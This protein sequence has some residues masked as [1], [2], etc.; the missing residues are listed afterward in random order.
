MT[1]MPPPK[2]STEGPR[3]RHVH[4]EM[5]QLV[6]ALQTNGPQAPDHLADLVGA[7]YWEPHRF[8]RALAFAVS[9]GLALD[10]GA[11]VRVRFL[12]NASRAAGSAAG[13]GAV[14]LVPETSIVRRGALTGVFVAQ[15]GKARLR[16]IR[17]GRSAGDR[18]EVLAGLLA[19][20]EVVLDP[21]G[22]TDGRAVEVSR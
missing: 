18:V 7:E 1:P 8:E 4:Y 12:G 3:D 15:E 14:L 21:S 20:D 16:W 6:R 9:D 5:G 22:L 10:P 11:Y 17:L 2:A 19:G 13:T